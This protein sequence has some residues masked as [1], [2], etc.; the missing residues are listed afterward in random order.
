MRACIMC[1]NNS[2]SRNPHAN[3]LCDGCGYCDL[4]LNNKN[5]PTILAGLSKKW[6]RKQ[7]HFYKSKYTGE[8]VPNV[9]EKILS[10]DKLHCFKCEEEIEM[11]TY[12]TRTP[13]QR[14]SRARQKYYHDTCFKKM[15]Y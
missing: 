8:R 15:H 1:G 5:E 10:L 4:V 9:I 2:W 13:P 11:G 3:L 7:D 14:S 6:E 12:F